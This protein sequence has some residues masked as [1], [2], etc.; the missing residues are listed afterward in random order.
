MHSQTKRVALCGVFAAL[1][2]VVMFL[3]GM[4]PLATFTAPAIAGLLLWP[5]ALEFNLQS[6]LMAWAVVSALSFFIVPDKE[7]SLIFIFLLGYY[8]MLKGKLDKI[9]KKAIQWLAK[10]TAFNLSVFVMYSLILFV[11]PIGEIVEEFSGSSHLFLAGLVL[12]GNFAFIVYDF[13]LVKIRLVYYY[14]LRPMVFG[15]GR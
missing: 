12:L 13:A 3:C 14:R 9:H 1:S 10:M 7:M 4:L 5:V 6:G 2:T 15:R 8:P 11:F